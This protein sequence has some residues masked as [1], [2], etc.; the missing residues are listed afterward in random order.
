MKLKLTIVYIAIGFG[1]NSAFS[2]NQSII[3]DEINVIG[4]ISKDNTDPLSYKPK[5]ND[6]VVT[7][8][9]LRSKSS[10]LGNALSSELGVH[11]SQFG[12]G[13]S[14]PII[15]GQE[16]VR[17]K[18]L[19]N[20]S[21]VIDMAELSPDHNHGVDTLLS[22]KVEII[23]GA[24]TLLYA[25]ASSAGVINVIDERIPTEVPDL[26]V[27]EG[28]IRY[29]SNSNEKLKTIGLTGGVGKYLAVRIEG[30]HR[31]SD[32]YKVPEFNLG[33]KIDYVPDTQNHT[34]LGSFGFNFI[35]SKGSIGASVTER[36]ENYGI[37]GHDH[38]MDTCHAHIK[39]E[40]DN[41]G[42]YLGMYP[43]LT[44]DTD[45]LNAHF[46]GCGQ[47]SLDHKHS[48]K[49]P[50]GH[51]HHL[52]TKGPNV[53]SFSRRKDIKAQLNKPLRGLD[54]LRIYYTTTK[55]HHDEKDGA[56]VTNLFNN[57][58]NN[59]RIE[60][61][62]TPTSGFSG[63]IGMQY[64]KKSMDANIPRRTPCSTLYGHPCSKSLNPNEFLK[65]ITEQDRVHWALIP[66]KNV[67]TSFFIAE[68]FKYKDFVFDA[69]IRTE[70]QRIHIDYDVEQ[71]KNNRR[72]KYDRWSD[73]NP[74]KK[75]CSPEKKSS[76]WSWSGDPN[77]DYDKIACD[78]EIDKI[79][80]L[81]SLSNYNERA[82]SYAFSTLW[83]FKPKY[84]VT[85]AYSHNERHPTPMELYYHGNHIATSSY[86][87][88]NKN[89]TKEISDSYEINSAY[90]GDKLRYSI[91]LYYSYFK[92]RIFNQTLSKLGNLSLNRYAQ[93]KAEYYGIEGRLDYEI[94]NH[95]DVGVF[96][97]YVRGKLFDLAPKQTRTDGRF[98]EYVAQPDQNAPRVPPARLGL[99]IKWD[100]TD[101]LSSD[102][103]YTYVFKQRKV[104]PLENKT[105]GYQ[106]L[107]L[108][109]SY[110]HF[111]KD[112]DYSI[113]MKVDNAFN[114]KVYSHTSY[115]SFVP[116]MGRNITMGVNF[117][118]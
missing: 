115:L 20:G 22:S 26:L 85:L 23:R 74:L 44:D 15:R 69:A 118:F 79:E 91:S 18:V 98:V 63:V 96:G 4:N 90:Q 106:L 2:Q 113:F 32:I 65:P 7:K 16:G 87:H 112:I 56:V 17:L 47:I 25:N 109:L 50:Y 68:K 42:Y 105:E 76:P 1:M 37:P 111:Y 33:E 51:S 28:A 52:G 80:P 77:P 66:N 104:A 93:S 29:N 61:F 39:G 75:V 102:L 64:Q 5:S 55:Y 116:Q 101:A 31:G 24:T 57:N 34:K 11:S 110:D 100:I 49:H 21:D 36:S 107:N 14:S 58:G 89:L 40:N 78:V 92:N 72:I 103:E 95:L 99:R 59:T 43:H 12:G 117:S 70:K 8:R 35:G 53:V 13:A 86:E 84:E 71:L 97:D 6:I 60:L 38:Q 3:L 94:N 27:G 9:E 114:K 41:H 48:H 82:T 88:G 30:L 19:S 108:G 67:Q 45:L 10:T 83:R 81:P 62:H 54:R 46:D 73:S